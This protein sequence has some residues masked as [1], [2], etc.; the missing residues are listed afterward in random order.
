[1]LVFMRGLNFSEN[2][3]LAC[4]RHASSLLI[5]LTNYT[6]ALKHVITGVET[7]E[8]PSLKLFLV[9]GWDCQQENKILCLISVEVTFTV[10]LDLFVSGH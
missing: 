3:V 1:M 4:F 10:P 8:S 6:A 5:I 7:R 9:Y 2:R